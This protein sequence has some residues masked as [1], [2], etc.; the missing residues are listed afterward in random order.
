M[1]PQRGDVYECP[2]CHLKLSVLESGQFSVYERAEG[3]V[4]SCGE[5]MTLQQS[6]STSTEQ[7]ARTTGAT[8]SLS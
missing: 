3:I 6:G 5:K 2:Q 4:C 7:P 8:A 1:I